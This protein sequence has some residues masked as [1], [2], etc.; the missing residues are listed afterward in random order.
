MQ[1]ILTQK[2][3]VYFKEKWSR[4]AGKDPLLGHVDGFQIDPNLPEG[5]RVPMRRAFVIPFL[6]NHKS[7]SAE[8]RCYTDEKF[9]FHP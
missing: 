5:Q 4:T 9:S 2:Y 7:S 6:M 1:A 8:R 3:L